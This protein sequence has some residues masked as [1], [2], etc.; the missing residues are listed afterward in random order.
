MNDKE[1]LVIAGTDP[2]YLTAEQLD[3]MA[4]VC[5]GATLDR[6]E[7][8]RDLVPV[9][10]KPYTN[11]LAQINHA[12]CHLKMDAWHTCDTTHCLGGWTTTLS[13]PKGKK[14]ESN[15]GMPFAAAAIL[16]K[17]RPDAPLPDFYASNEAA[18][19]FIEA[20]AAEEIGEK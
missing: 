17:S 20:R 8:I 14:L 4:A 13:G 12:G 15:I 2:A 19:A 18:M 16:R 7:E 5:S 10:E 11:I 1:L 9:L 3:R 6:M